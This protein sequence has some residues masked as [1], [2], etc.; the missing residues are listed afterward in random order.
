[1]LDSSGNDGH[2][3]SKENGSPCCESTVSVLDVERAVRERYGAAA[4][5]KEN[6]LCCPVDYD[7]HYLAIIPQEI[8]DRDY[9]CGDPSRHLQQGETV[10]DLGSGGGK[11]CYIAAQIVGAKGRVIGVDRNDE[12]LSLANK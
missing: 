4:Q 8:L 11:I 6:A 10:L 1:M 9:G 3:K 7:P 5:A 2:S 12:M